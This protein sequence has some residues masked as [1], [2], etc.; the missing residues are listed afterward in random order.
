MCSLVRLVSNKF[1]ANTLASQNGFRIILNDRFLADNVVFRT[2]TATNSTHHH[3]QHYQHRFTT[4]QAVFDNVNALIT[5]NQLGQTFAV[6]HIYSQQHLVHLGDIITLNKAIPAEVGEKI[7]L[8]RCLLVGNQNF[9]LVGRP[10]LNRDLVQ[11]E[12]TIIEKTMSQT[13]FNM[14]HIPRNHGFRLYRFARYPM[15][16]LRITEI[17]VCHPLNTT[18]QQIN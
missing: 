1:G 5:T 4:S 11:V 6:I 16:M 8:E 17:T 9:T 10:V 2:V 12:A 3:H 7:K 13:Y 14:F 18:Q 15:S